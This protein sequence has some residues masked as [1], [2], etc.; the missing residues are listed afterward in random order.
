MESFIDEQ[1]IIEDPIYLE[2]QPKL[3][4][5][6]NS[7]GFSKTID[8]SRLAGCKNPSRNRLK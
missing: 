7:I 4:Y 1:T 2:D 5:P 6:L 8:F 3:T